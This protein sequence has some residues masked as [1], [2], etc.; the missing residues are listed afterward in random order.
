MNIN[1]LVG[2]VRLENQYAV[3]PVVETFIF[4]KVSEHFKDYIVEKQVKL[5]LA[6]RNEKSKNMFGPGVVNTKKRSRRFDIVITNPTTGTKHIIEIKHQ[7]SQGTAIDSVGIYLEDLE[8]LKTFT[9]SEKPFSI[10]VLDFLPLGTY[11]AL[12]KKKYFTS[13]PAVITRFNEYASTNDVLILMHNTYEEEMYSS[14]F[15]AI[16]ARL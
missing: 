5:I 16:K 7:V 14:F 2:K 8:Q 3:S 13:E 11:N 12:T 6:D 4:E 9:K 1:E 10:M 15:D